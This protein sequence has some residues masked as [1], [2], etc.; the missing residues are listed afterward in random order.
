MSLLKEGLLW[1][2]NNK[3]KMLR[4]VPGTEWAHIKYLGSEIHP[5]IWEEEGSIINV[6]FSFQLLKDF[7]YTIF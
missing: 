7:Y 5:F 6:E 3:G 4:R 2:L 1:E